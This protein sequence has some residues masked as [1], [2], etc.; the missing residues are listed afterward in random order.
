MLSAGNRFTHKD[1]DRLKQRVRKIYTKLSPVK[2]EKKTQNWNVYTIYSR[3]TQKS[4][5]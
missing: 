2:K 1:A 3:E 4:I 5:K